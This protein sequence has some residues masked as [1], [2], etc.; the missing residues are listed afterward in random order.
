[1]LTNFHCRD[2]TNLDHFIATPLGVL[3]NLDYFIAPPSSV[4]TNSIV[5]D[6]VEIFKRAYMF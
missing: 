3:T 4:L 1:M 5:P 2:L 6:V